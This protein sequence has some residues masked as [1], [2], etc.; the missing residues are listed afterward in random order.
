MT[1]DGRGGHVLHAVACQ[2][3]DP[4]ACVVMCYP[5]FEERK[6][7]QR[8]YVT[9]ARM[10]AAR[11]IASLR[12]DYFACGNSEGHFREATLERWISDAACAM[13]SAGGMAGAVMAMGL[14][15]GANIAWAAAERTPGCRRL[16]LWDRIEDTSRYLAS[17][18][19]RNGIRDMFARRAET[20]STARQGESCDLA[21]YEV[22][23]ALCEEFEAGPT[24]PASQARDARIMPARTRP[25]HA[26]SESDDA[27]AI[28]ARCAPFWS[29][30]DADFRPFVLQ[31]ADYFAGVA[32]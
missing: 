11:S 8:A 21:G 27:D 22:G 24:A 30:P 29:L 19:R 20:P 17:E 6:Y 2:P 14:R 18:R 3:A 7:A 10:L 25:P 12:F 1:L 4:R 16:L 31:S 15:M 26:D 28:V 9:L 5:L 13:E 32:E 23:A